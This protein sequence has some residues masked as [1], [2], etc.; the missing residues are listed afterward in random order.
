MTEDVY[1]GSMIQQG[2][3]RQCIFRD[4]PS[5]HGACHG[6]FRARR[7][8]SR[9]YGTTARHGASRDI[10]YITESVTAHHGAEPITDSH[11]TD[12]RECCQG[13][14]RRVAS[15]PSGNWL[16]DK[17]IPAQCIR[18]DHSTPWRITEYHRDHGKSWTSR[19]SSGSITERSP[20]RRI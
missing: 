10:T 19:N 4:L 13:V 15:L 9:N 16:S 5:R 18:E 20:S 7:I 11:G 8:P 1:Y 6:R 12:A 17:D 3:S 2:I 14:S